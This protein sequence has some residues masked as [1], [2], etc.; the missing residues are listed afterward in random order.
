MK[1][2]TGLFATGLLALAG[3]ANAGEFSAT[4]TAVS[5]YDFRGVSLNTKDPALQ[6][7][8]D[9]AHDSGFYAGIWASNFDYGR[10]FDGDIEVDL[11]AGWAGETGGGLGWD[12]GI[13]WYTY[14]DSSSSATKLEVEDYPEAYIG[15]SHGPVSFKQWYT[16][17]YVGADQD[18]F[19]TELNASFELPAEFAL[20]LHAGYNYGEA[21][22][23]LNDDE[24]FDYS[25]GIGKT[26]GRFDLELK[27]TGTDLSGA[28]K[29]EADTF[30]NEARVVLAVSTTF[31]WSA[32]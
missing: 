4:V 29:V 26:V 2:S 28:D 1:Y 24:Y 20:N 31:P 23:V 11:Y 18:E 32:E 6:G 19:Y 21:F 3:A 25:I 30:N 17:D 9:Y 13:V 7:S 10:D 12:V 27:V 14:P 5:D 16:N 8:V 15:F 22:N